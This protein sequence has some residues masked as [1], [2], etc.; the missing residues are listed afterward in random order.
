MLSTTNF[1]LFD[2]PIWKLFEAD[3]ITDPCGDKYFVFQNLN[4]N[5][6]LKIKMW[7][8]FC[9][10][11]LY[12]CFS[13][14]LSTGTN[15]RERSIKTERPFASKVILAVVLKTGMF[16]YLAFDDNL[17]SYLLFEVGHLAYVWISW[18]HQYFLQ[19]SLGTI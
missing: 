6:Y 4:Q 14:D 2:S 3:N 1:R 7:T 12:N 9:I 19:I 18:R 8:Y 15:E 5:L 10:I 16:I 17:L 13:H 11:L